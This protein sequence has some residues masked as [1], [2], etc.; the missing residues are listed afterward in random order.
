MKK[1]RVLKKNWS[2]VKPFTR[3]CSWNGNGV[4]GWQLMGAVPGGHSGG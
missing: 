2:D 3:A 4:S 1:T